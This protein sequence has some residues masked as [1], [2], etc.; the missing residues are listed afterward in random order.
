MPIGGDSVLTHHKNPTR[1]GVYVQPALT[2]TAVA[3]LHQD[4]TFK[5]TGIQGAMYAQPLFVDGQGAG[6]D[7]VIV[8][9]EANNVY[10]LDGATGATV[11]AKSFGT[12]VPLASMPCGNI[13]PYGVT[14]TPVIDAASRTLFFDAMVTPDGGPTKQH[15]VYALSVDTGAV[16]SGWPV[17]VG[18]KAKSGATTFP[19]AHQS[20]R[21][22]LAVVNGTLYVP[23]GGLYGDCTPY[24]GW[25]VAVPIGDPTQVT[26]WA[27]SAQGGGVWSTGGVS[28][29]G[30][31]LYVTTG[32]TFNA[33]TW[34]GGDAL[35]QLGVGASFGTITASFAPANWP[36]LDSQDRDMGTAPVLFDLAGA[37][38]S[39]LAIVFGKDG[40]AYLLDRN[41]LGGVGSALGANAGACTPTNTTN[42]CATLHVA[43]NVILG[44]SAVYTTTTATYVAFRGAGAKCTS[45]GGGNLGTLKVV[46]GT[47]PTLAG[48]WCATAGSGSPMVT[49]SNGTA[50][51]IVWMMGA[52]GDNR[53]HAFDGDTG[54][55]VPFTGSTTTI[56]NMRRFNVPIAAKG[57][58]FVPADNAVVAFTL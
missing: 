3:T 21:G 38:P 31:S 30:T 24:H 9:T 43:S 34:A 13:D 29:D 57:R 58:I 7:L 8:A 26:A 37:T 55:A 17:D 45:G 25:V 35:V 27:T 19:T 4:T 16:L 41:N 20:Q 1:D 50:D 11:W 39:T 48:S 46:P 32:N 42:A 23:F 33:T 53:L 6:P 14:G 47:P 5:P 40:N 15:L 54:A 10:A 52:E 36:T 56:P 44:A 51:V 12:S 28:T 49:T 2:K 22:A 18:A